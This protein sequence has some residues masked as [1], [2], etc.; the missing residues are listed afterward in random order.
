MYHRNHHKRELNKKLRKWLNEYDDLKSLPRENKGYLVPVKPFQDGWK[1][2]F[3]LRDDIKNR[4]DS[5]VLKKVLNLVN[6]TLFSHKKDFMY[7]DWKQRRKLPIKQELKS[8]T[9]KQYE[10]L[11]EQ[12]KSYFYKT[13]EVKYIG[14]YVYEKIEYKIKK[15][16]LFVYK[17]YPRMI[18]FRWIPDSEYES[19]MQ[20]LEYKLYNQYERE[21]H[22]L[23]YWSNHH[24]RAY[25]KKLKY[26]LSNTDLKDI[27]QLGEKKYGKRASRQN[28]KKY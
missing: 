13:I 12:M 3:V 16:Y 9:E 21:L 4:S 10:A 14:S 23:Q 25:N 8:I 18:N 2:T 6:N 27:E 17:I 20:Y 5:F 28:F 26:S 7:Y 1:R 22:N 24:W 19:R 11:D 15:P